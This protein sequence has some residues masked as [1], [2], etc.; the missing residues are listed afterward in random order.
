MNPCPFQLIQPPDATPAHS[1]TDHA[2]LPHAK[3]RRLC[4]RI[5]IQ[6]AP[7]ISSPR[8]P[9]YLSRKRKKNTTKGCSHQAMTS[10]Q[11]PP[12]HI[13]RQH[14]RPPLPLVP[15]LPVPAATL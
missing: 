8:L 14:Q 3:T 2:H 5:L 1:Y 13:P 15:V 11:T 7:H 9:K 12:S 4:I 6:Q 10:I